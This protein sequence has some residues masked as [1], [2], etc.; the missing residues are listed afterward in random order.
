[1]KGTHNSYFG[2]IAEGFRSMWVGLKLTVRH[3]IDAR[4]S[5]KPIGMQDGNYFTQDK[6]I[7]TLQYPYESLPVPDNGRYRLHNEIDDCIV[8]DLCAK[9]C[10][11]DCIEIEPVKATEEIGKTSDGTTKRLYAAKFDIDMAKC[12][13]CGLCTTVCP[14]ECLTMTKTYDYSEFDIRNMV[15]HFTDLS[16]EEAE[17]KKKEAEQKQK[18]KAA[19]KSE[20]DKNKVNTESSTTKEKPAEGEVKKPAFKPVFKPVIKPAPKKEEGQSE[21]NKKEEGDKE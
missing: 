8:C 5:R 1:M 21:E 7:V 3:F 9:I 10:P 12:C 13:Y 19:A 15:Y 17:A 18:E 11:V 16:P 2:N 14:T 4:K 20:A 6:G